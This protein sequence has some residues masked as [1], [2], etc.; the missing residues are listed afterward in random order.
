MRAMARAMRITA[1]SSR[2]RRGVAG[3]A[4]RAELD[5]ADALLGD[6]DGVVRRARAGAG[7]RALGQEELAADGVE[8][9]FG[10]P[11]RAVDAADLFVGGGEDAQAGGAAARSGA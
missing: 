9:V 2:G 8:L 3:L 4:A 7:E 10:E 11:L 1:L 6:L 5:R